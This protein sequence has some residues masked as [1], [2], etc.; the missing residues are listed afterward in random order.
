MFSTLQYD[1]TSNGPFVVQSTLPPFDLKRPSKLTR[2]ACINCRISKLKC[3]GEQEG[4]QR[5]RTKDIECGYPKPPNGRRNIKPSKRHTNPGKG[6]S[7]ADHSR[8]DQR[9]SHS[10]PKTPTHD[11]QF[12]F[13]GETSP[14][15]MLDSNTGHWLSQKAFREHYGDGLSAD[16]SEG[17]QEKVPPG[18]DGW[19]PML[20]AD[21]TPKSPNMGVNIGTGSPTVSGAPGSELPSLTEIA[22]ESDLLCFCSWDAIGTFDY[23]QTTL[24]WK[25][26]KKNTVTSSALL[27]CQK[28]ALSECENLL[29]CKSCTSQPKYITLIIVM[30]ENLLS[31]MQGGYQIQSSSRQWRDER[32]NESWDEIEEN[33]DRPQEEDQT[34]VPGDQ[35][36]ESSDRPDEEPNK[37]VVGRW[38]LDSDDQ[39][40]VIQSLF[41]A[42][43]VRLMN[44]VARLERIS[45][46]HQWTNQ[47]DRIRDIRGRCHSLS[48]RL[49][50]HA[51]FLD[52]AE[53]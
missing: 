27:Q 26:E 45:N 41:S 50:E 3:S 44:L 22:F 36:G 9:K 7:E 19:Q 23:I 17:L 52:Q 51:G 40:S 31:S 38:Q 16:V 48:R 35:C 12:D 15:D 1:N 20:P 21:T 30:C 39:L 4:C 34:Q 53:V 11:I 47:G 49:K 10:S 6:A 43:V 5:C 8:N 14:H 13:A 25:P 42:R 46:E 28:K 29:A 37:V 2:L 24:V 18:L 32:G 33:E